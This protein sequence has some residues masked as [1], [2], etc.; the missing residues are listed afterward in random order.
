MLGDP[1]VAVNPQDDVDL[2]TAISGVDG[3]DLSP[4]AYHSPT[5]ARARD[6]QEHAIAEFAVFETSRVEGGRSILVYGLDFGDEEIAFGEECSY[7][8]F[9]GGGSLAEDA[10]GEVDGAERK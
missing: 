9:V 1:D 10:A 8:E 7:L 3:P 6:G 4:R 2:S 5:P